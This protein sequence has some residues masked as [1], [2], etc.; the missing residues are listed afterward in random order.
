M[1]RRRGSLDVGWAL[2]LTPVLWGATFPAAKIAIRTVDVLAFTGWSRLIGFLTV[3]AALQ[4]MAGG[5][6]HA[7][8]LRRAL[9]PGALLGAL[10]FG[11]YVLQTLGLE[12]TTATNAGFITGLY[13]VFTPVLG[14]VLFGQPAGRLAWAAVA[15]S[16]GGLALLSVQDLGALRAHPGDLLVLASAVLWAAQ[17]VAIG[18]LTERHSVILLSLGQM[19]FAAALHLVVAAPGGLDVEGAA[20]IWPLLVVTG[21]LGSG[22]AFTL[23][24][25]AQRELSPPRA[26]I[27]LAGES[28]AAA[29]FAFAWLGERLLPHQ[30]AGAAL[31][32]AAMVTSELGARR[33]D[34]QAEA[35][36][37][38]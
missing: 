5:Q 23:Q 7:R 15:V 8:D 12:R 18:R 34:L 3:L 24:L 35:A 9:G 30:W 29:A 26:A 32:V 21:V 4:L 28:V 37:P 25:L 2:F 10:I 31:V 16:V 38:T 17:V 6:V 20:D 14:L 1:G 19:G 11:G 13:V 22:V 33:A 36:A 27:I